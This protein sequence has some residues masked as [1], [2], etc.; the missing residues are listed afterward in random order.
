MT[1]CQAALLA[2]LIALLMPMVMLAI[3]L[4]MMQW[5]RIRLRCKKHCMTKS[6]R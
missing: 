6:K 3:G 5:D 1:Q 2:W 4:L